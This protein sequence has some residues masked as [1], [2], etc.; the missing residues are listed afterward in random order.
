MKNAV[1]L[2]CAVALAALS[3]PVFAAEGQGHQ[4]F[5]R[6]EI[7]S[8]DFEVSAGGFSVSDDDTAIGAGGGYWF[9]ANFGVEG[10]YTLLY[11]QELDRDLDFDVFSL[12]GGVVA[13]K[14]FGADGN[15]FYIGGRA[16][17]AYVTAQVRDGFDVE[18][19]ESSFGPYFG[20]NAGYDINRHFGLGLNYTRY[21]ADLDDADIDADVLSVS[22][23][24]RF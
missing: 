23:E 21:Q 12:A 1:S 24:Y 19:D 20:V 17:L 8:T 3:M 2:A 14:N 4:A 9:N 15:G 5:V 11:N 22:G 10:N 18:D 7:G 16:G 6:G 13:K